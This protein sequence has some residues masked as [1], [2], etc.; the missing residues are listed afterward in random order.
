MIRQRW[1]VVCSPLMQAKQDG[2]IGIYNLSEEF[3]CWRCQSLAKQRLIPTEAHRDIADTDDS[4]R[5]FHFFLTC[6]ASPAQHECVKQS[7]IG[8]FLSRH[9]GRSIQGR[10]IKIDALSATFLLMGRSS[11]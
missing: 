10:H 1:M 7:G 9:F 5:T 6:Q 3:V 4:P 8:R 2:S 11:A